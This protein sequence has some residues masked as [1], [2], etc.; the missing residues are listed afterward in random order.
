MTNSVYTASKLRT[1]TMPELRES[2]TAFLNM[3]DN[4]TVKAKANSVYE[5]YHRFIMLA[6]KCYDTADYIRRYTYKHY[7]VDYHFFTDG[8]VNG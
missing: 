5:D 2:N 1:M 4:F 6:N 8:T 3:G 7:N